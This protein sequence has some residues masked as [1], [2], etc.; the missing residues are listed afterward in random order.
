MADWTSKPGIII[1]LLL[2]S[3]RLCKYNISK[4]FF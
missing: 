2:K 1:C 4:K 3:M